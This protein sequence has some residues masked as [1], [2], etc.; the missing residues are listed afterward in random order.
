MKRFIRVCGG[1]L[2]LIALISSIFQPPQNVMAQS[3]TSFDVAYVYLG[4]I[5]LA[6]V[7]NGQATTITPLTQDAE[8]GRSGCLQRVGILICTLLAASRIVVPASTLNKIP[9]IL[10]FT[11]FSILFF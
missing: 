8:G 7:V 11:T 2:A 10:A 6:S 5:Y 3:G 9:L 1:I 4:N